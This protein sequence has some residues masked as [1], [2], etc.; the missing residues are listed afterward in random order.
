MMGAG[1]MGAGMM[2][3][4]GYQQ[5]QASQQQFGQQF[6]AGASNMMFNTAPA[7]AG[8]ALAIGGMAA[9]MV[10]GA[11]KGGGRGY[12]AI[13]GAA[14]VV[15]Y[16]DPFTPV[17]NMMG[18]GFNAGKG[19]G[20]RMGMNMM[21]R[22]AM[23]IA[24]GAGAAAL[25]AAG[26]MAVTAAVGHGLGQMHTGA[27]NRSYG[28]A[29]A[30]QVMPSA[31]PG[32]QRGQEG[33]AT[34][35][36]M[37]DMSEQLG[38]GMKDISGFGKKL[39]S[40]RAFQTVRSAKEFRTKF[41]EVM[42]AVKE[43]ATMTQGTLDDA[44]GMFSSM[45]QS[46]FYSTADIKAQAAKNKA[47]EMTTGIS[48][49]TYGAV[50]QAGAQT[51]RAYG[52]RGRYGA[53][54]A[55]QSVAGVSRAVR[56]G[57]ISEEMVMENGGV[58]RVGM[59]LA[60][61]QM[62]FLGSSSGRAMIAQGMGTGG[63]PDAE[64][65][66]GMMGGDMTLQGLVT[67][68][69]GRGMGVLGQAGSRESKEA[70]MPYASAMMVKMAMMSNSQIG[71]GNTRGN[72]I[73][74][75]GHNAG[76]SKDEA[77]MQLAQ[78]AEMGPGMRDE[79]SSQQKSATMTAYE[80]KKYRQSFS[81][82]IAN[83][84][85]LGDLNDSFRSFGSSTESAFSGIARSA[86]RG[87]SGEDNEYTLESGR[88]SQFLGRGS[89]K[90]GDGKARSGGI[91][92]GV[93]SGRSMAEEYGEADFEGDI[94]IN[95]AYMKATG[96][97]T[98]D[99][100]VKKDRDAWAAKSYTEAD[101]KYYDKSRLDA[102][103]KMRAGAAQDAKE[104][105]FT[106]EQLDYAKT[107]QGTDADFVKKTNQRRQADYAR[108]AFG[109]R[110]GGKYFGKAYL[111]AA[112][113]GDFANQM[114]G[115]AG[116]LIG[117]GSMART[118]DTATDQ[119]AMKVFLEQTGQD[120]SVLDT[121]KGRETTRQKI[122]GS[123]HEAAK[124]A[125]K[126]MSRRPTDSRSARDLVASKKGFSETLD[127][128]IA[129]GLNNRTFATKG[130]RV[131]S[132]KDVIK[133]S[134]KAQGLFADLIKLKGKLVGGG[135]EHSAEFNAKKEEL[136]KLTG[137]EGSGATDILNEL[138]VNM[139]QDEDIAKDLVDAVSAG[140]EYSKG[141]G[142]VV[143]A[144]YWK[145]RVSSGIGGVDKA[146]ASDAFKKLTP[147]QQAK[148]K[149]YRDIVGNSTPNMGGG[150]YADAKGGLRGAE[151]EI[152]DDLLKDGVTADEREIAGSFAGGGGADVLD[153]LQRISGKH[154]NREMDKIFGFDIDTEEGKAQSEA[155][156]KQIEAADPEDRT[157]LIL[158][159]LEKDKQGIDRGGDS[160]SV[161]GV[162]VT[163]PEEAN[164]MMVRLVESLVN[165]LRSAGVLKDGTYGEQKPA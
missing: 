131:V 25:P 82:K 49:E 20:A 144:E 109:E 136:L 70:A 69:H 31:A 77:S 121:A 124:Q 117:R 116:D 1:M 152:L 165:E 130:S 149:G 102:T 154:G 126:G 43:I 46:G 79:A 83:N 55:S 17:A 67:S 51:A 93:S 9:P 118:M 90:S 59:T 11:F 45:R 3:N 30:N 159:M 6:G 133:K 115:A 148:M 40:Q 26:A 65:M 151:A 73:G 58:E 10:H 48:Q 97:K 161:G 113:V 141:A 104:N 7:M 132:L 56:S 163:S 37:R 129:G 5:Q 98:G 52:M 134:S 137:G 2:G 96:K 108:Q 27:M 95:H 42:G 153:K 78:L 94:A 21:G 61:K 99:V 85:G 138:L 119:A 145:Q 47:R 143:T 44:M 86:S 107:Q 60:Q 103:D 87:W 84:R 156:R 29:F 12:K 4:P 106:K 63:M 38:V 36:M 155:M 140:G 92:G 33:Q 13:R 53:E 32:A 139:E 160:T 71:R 35:M 112:M 15:D 16:A 157:K 22:G 147:E 50:G 146:M 81:G 39:N 57:A 111:G 135:K 162:S 72:L 100:L 41:K 54:M 75:M 150:S 101:G 88:G 105:P 114:Q 128:V 64:R 120:T 125:Q 8:S 28:Q 66:R 164:L 14:N 76:L 19:L 123:D 142:D 80:Q 23:G 24:F 110:G 122:M 68:A 62:K 34:G 127:T 74:M 18:R 158:D 91:W 89:F